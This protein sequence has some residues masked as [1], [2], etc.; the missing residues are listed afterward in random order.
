[1][2]G[3][4]RDRTPALPEPTEATPEPVE[5]TPDV[6]RPSITA[7]M[8]PEQRSLRARIAV[9]TSWA[10]TVDRTSRTAPGTDASPAR[11]SYWE[12]RV[13]PDRRMDEATRAKA[14]ENA[15]TA[16]YQRMAY[17]SAQTRR[18]RRGAA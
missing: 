3:R 10:N 4:R 9:H 13:D 8:T 11:L 16:H 15:R 14:A 7:D 12:K 5:D 1:M 2:T 18:R 17:R 6:T